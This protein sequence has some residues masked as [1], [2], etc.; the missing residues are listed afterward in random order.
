ME[1]SFDVIVIGDGVAAYTVARKCRSAGDCVAMVSMTRSRPRRGREALGRSARPGPGLGLGVVT[2][3]KPA[4]AA[5]GEHAQGIS[6]DALAALDWREALRGVRSLAQAMPDDHEHFLASIG[7][8]MFHGRVRFTG[9]RTV[10]VNG[11]ELR[12]RRIH[13]APCARPA[14]LGIPGEPYLI[15]TEELMELPGLPRRLVFVGGQARSFEL[16]HVAARAGAHVTILE[17]RDHLLEH[18]DPDLVSMLVDHTRQLGVDIHLEA[19][20]QAVEPSCECLVVHAGGPRGDQVFEA[21]LVIHGAGR[22]L[23]LLGLD[24]DRAGVAHDGRGVQVNKYLQ[25]VS[26]PAVYA[27]GDAVAAG[28]RLASVAACQARVVAENLIRGNHCTAS[29][30]PMPAVLCTVPPMASVGLQ[31]IAALEHGFELEVHCERTPAWYTSR[32]PGEA[33]SGFKVLVDRRTGRILGAHLLGP[34]A[35]EQINLFAL[36]IGA[37]MTSHDITRALFS[38]SSA[39]SEIQYM[40]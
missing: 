8:A 39:A 10:A 1:H 13:L 11:L 24:L 4:H 40:V 30:P 17:P 21:D 2:G 33:C 37:G 5:P 6:F 23:D 28:P 9:P 26:N 3:R 20:V 36:A 31:E 29:A 34:D 19:S 16:A 14:D 25:S 7:I 32:R 12:G 27:A 35:D 18:F 15:T 22:V 38:H